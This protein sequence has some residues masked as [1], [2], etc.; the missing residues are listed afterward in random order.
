[1]ASDSHTSIYPD[2]FYRVSLKAVIRD[3]RGNVLV[4]KEYDS[5]TWSLPGGGLEHTETIELALARELEEEVG[6]KGTFTF[7]LKDTARFWI[8][9]REAWLLW[10]VYDVTPDTFDF[11]P[12][13]DS[14][15]I[16][17]INPSE[18]T[19]TSLQE[20]WIADNL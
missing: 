13:V 6:F 4:N 20:Q 7:T 3:D 11:S 15:E 2:T 17:F 9:S 8:E 5:T 16:A 18:F 10:I 14:S 1:M 12:G 19:A